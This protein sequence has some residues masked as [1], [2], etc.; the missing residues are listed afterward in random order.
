MEK[1]DTG[2]DQL[3]VEKED[4]VATIT[5]NRPQA[6][7]ALSTELTPALRR[8]I[9]QLAE[10]QD[11]GVLLITGAGSAF[12]AGGDIKGMGKE[13]PKVS[14]QRIV[15]KISDYVKK[16][17]TGA[18][19]AL[20]KPTIAALP[21]AAAGAGLAIAL[22]CDIRIAATS[23][24]VTT[25][26]IHVGL[27]GDYGIAAL[28]TRAVGTARA[29][30]LMFTGDRI[31]AERCEKIGIFNRVVPD[32]SLQEHAFEMALTLASGP[33]EALRFHEGKFR[34]SARE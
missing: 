5:L 34:R 9:S 12:C 20:R 11:V 22:A 26:Y 17:L 10:D 19:V 23:A 2:T 13:N 4:G 21:G 25:G 3:L 27:S 14:Q 15:L 30:E 29:R 24:F 7:N 16:L 28:L 32:A 8:M 31:S 18:L 33:R 1:I 6:R